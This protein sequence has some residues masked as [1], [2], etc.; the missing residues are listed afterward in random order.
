[1]KKGG[2][3][4]EGLIVAARYVLKPVELRICVEDEKIHQIL[5][6]FLV[7]PKKF[8]DQ[9]KQALQQMPVCY[10]YFEVI[11][12]AN[13]IPNPFNIDVVEAY[14]IGN[15]LLAKVD[16]TTLKESIRFAFGKPQALD[17][18]ELERRIGSL[19]EYFLPHHTFHV[20]CLGSV[21]GKVEPIP[22][23]LDLCRISWGQ[24]VVMLDKKVW[25]NR[26]PVVQD[27][28]GKFII[29]DKPQQF[30][31][32]LQNLPDVKIDV[33]DWV[34]MHWGQ[35]C[36]RVTRDQVESLKKYTLQ[37]LKVAKSWGEN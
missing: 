23:V 15:S 9:A 31:T 32:E 1:M 8:V 35:I 10:P 12:Q 7:N 2:E 13:G 3:N 11:A 4:M 25:V 20:Y 28:N 19:P 27:P 6:D 5:F 37:A 29:S 33:G 17:E 36:Q 22:K 24:V 34:T 26:Y 14:F 16:F 30:E 21:T 18:E